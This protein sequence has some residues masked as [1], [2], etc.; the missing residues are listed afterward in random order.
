MDPF[1][2][3]GASAF[4][5]QPMVNMGLANQAIG[6]PNGGARHMSSGHLQNNAMGDVYGV[7]NGLYSNGG[8]IQPQGSFGQQGHLA[9]QQLHT[10]QPPQSIDGYVLQG[11]ANH[12]QGISPSHSHAGAYS[13]LSGY[14]NVNAFGS[15]G[16][17]A[18]SMNDP[19]QRPN[20]GYSM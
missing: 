20:F 19:Y 17:G 12:S 18:V 8:G 7:Q 16:L 6:M 1:S 13:G 14:N 2:G 5:N 3:G 11:Q 15:G 4:N 10:M 9:Q